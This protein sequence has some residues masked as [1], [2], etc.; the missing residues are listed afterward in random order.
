MASFSYM[1]LKATNGVAPFK[2]LGVTDD[3]YLDYSTDEVLSPKAKFAV[4]SAPGSHNLV[5]IRS[6]SNNKYWAR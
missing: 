1:A 6:C 3:G 4:E 5:H 2:Y